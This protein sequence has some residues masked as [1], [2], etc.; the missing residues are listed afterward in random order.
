[1]A[2]NRADNESML[3]VKCPMGLDDVDLFAPGAQEFWKESYEILREQAPVFR[4]PGQGYEPG[5]DA[6]V[7]TKYEDIRRVA[8]DPDLFPT[9]QGAGSSGTSEIHD[10]IFTE[11]GFG[12]VVNSRQRLRPDMDSH[13]AHRE[14]LTE[15]WVGASGALQHRPM[16][17]A[18]A[19]RL[20]DNWIDRG[21]VEFVNEFA[22]PLPQAV[23]STILGFPLEDMPMTKQWEEAQ[24]RRFVY[25]H[26]PKSL[27]EDP[28]E[29][30]NA[31]ALVAFNHYIQE[32]IDE[33]RRN[34][35][36][37][38]ITFLTNVEFQGAPL[39]DGDIISV[40]SGM[41]IGGNETTQYALTAEAQLLADHPEV[42]DELRAD[43]SKIRFFVEEAMRLY[44]PTQGLSGRTVARDT[45]IH[46]V[47]IP[48]GSLLHLCYAAANRDPDL[49]EEP[50]KL[51]L[52]RKSP[53]R[54]LT[55]SIR[56]RG[57]P[58]AGLSRLEQNIATEV[59]LDRIDDIKL[60][61]GKND[62][63]HQPGIMLG[64]YDLHLE[65]TQARTPGAVS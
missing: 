36:E 17:E 13:R 26:G 53:G 3:Q 39:S 58:G 25:G 12:D 52:D 45:E 55:F 44:S 30:D 63:K 28:D 41:H 2:A 60:S 49:V 59:L 4:L 32:Q 23:I 47:K 57:C 5:A 37:D 61:P 21:E 33:K 64:L 9:R 62:F 56:P 40:V 54:H 8:R 48:K 15:P 38:M 42:V 7:L 19:H 31:R 35:K 20:V 27:M 46:G 6:Y 14:Q 16:I 10:A 50:D 29:E 51:R 22:A 24:V 1:M 34:P 18:Q 11:E 65:F 43:R